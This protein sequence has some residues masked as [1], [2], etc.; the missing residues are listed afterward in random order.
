MNETSATVI[1]VD[2]D[3]AIVRTENGGCGRCHESGG[4]GGAN[5][6]QMFCGNE[7]NWRVLNPRR[8]KIG[9]TVTVAV[10]EGAVRS[11]ASLLYGMPLFGL[12]AG[13][14][15]G[16]TLEPAWGGIAGGALGLAAAWI[17]VVRTLRRRHCDPRFQPHI[18]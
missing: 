5:I 18:V 12:I 9:E 6:S 14:V 2:G 7:R 17:G 8:A 15:F 3:Y 11:G 13:A 10:A 4:C 1:A 16:A